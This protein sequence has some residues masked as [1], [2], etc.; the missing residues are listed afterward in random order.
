MNDEEQRLR[1]AYAEYMSTKTPVIIIA[2]RYALNG[3]TMY[4]KWKR[5]GLTGRREK[6][7]LP[8]QRDSCR[9]VAESCPGFA[10]AYCGECT[11]PCTENEWHCNSCKKRATCPCLWGERFS[12]Y[13]A[14]KERN[15][16]AIGHY[17]YHWDD[18]EDDK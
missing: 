2:A 8:P 10:L 4:K 5:L 13:L 3:A 14:K 12:E 15:A 16:A 9:R 11:H 7:S 1:A 17:S 18:P 6:P